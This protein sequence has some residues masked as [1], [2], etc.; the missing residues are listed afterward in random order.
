MLRFFL[1]LIFILN[2]SLVLASNHVNKERMMADLEIIKNEFDIYYAPAHW[3]DVYLSWN[4]KKEIDKAKERILS[5]RQLTPM[6]YQQIVQNLFCS[7]QDLHVSVNFYSTEFASLPF[8]VQGTDHHYFVVWVDVEWKQPAGLNLQ[9]GDEICF[10]DNRPLDAIIQEIHQSTYGSCQEESYQRLSELQLTVRQGGGVKKIPQGKVKVNCRK[11]G[12]L[13]NLNFH[14]DWN[15]IPEEVKNHSL[16]SCFNPKVSSPLGQHA[17]FHKQRSLPL[18]ERLR[19]QTIRHEAKFLGAKK[20]PFSPLG[21]PTWKSHSQVFDAYTY[22]LDQGKRIGYVRIPDFHG[23][24]KHV[25]EFGRIITHMEENTDAL[26]IDVMN[27]PGGIS[28]YTYALLSLIIDKPLKN[29]KEQM[30]ITQEDVYFALQDVNLLNSV[31]ND[32]EA[33]AILGE[34]ICGYSVDKS[35]AIAIL[36]HAQFIKDQYLQGSFLTEAFPLEGVEFI[37]PHSRTHYSKPLLVL[38]NSLSISCADLFP[39]L[40]QDNNRAKILG[41]PTAGAGGYVLRKKYSNR[42]GVAEFTLTGSMIYRANGDP[43]ENLGVHP[44]YPYSLTIE[45]YTNQFVDF[46]SYINSVLIDFD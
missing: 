28:F 15:Y 44:D 24:K 1:F 29:L 10:F 30:S 6:Q 37:M 14:V 7:C 45:D 46:I 26:V 38:A 12:S 25:E 41:T 40:L 9:I 27:N 23:G 3:K 20:S 43:L 17:F 31:E 8:L 35:L 5:A 11:K 13:E 39:A 22:M 42:F 36:N 16:M 21:T 4:L 32:T 33:R 18:Y 2:T 34:E 19:S